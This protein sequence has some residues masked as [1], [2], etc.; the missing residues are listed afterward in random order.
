MRD[1]PQCQAPVD[2]HQCPSCGYSE[3]GHSGK[4][5][6]RKCNDAKCHNRGNF[7]ESTLGEGPRWCHLHYPPFVR[8]Q[9]NP[10]DKVK[11]E[12]L[13]AIRSVIRRSWSA[14]P[15]E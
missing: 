5:E 11:P 2:G 10:N 3:A 4:G 12:V 7:M 13:Q 8:R 9:V 1:C 6:S 14:L 15:D